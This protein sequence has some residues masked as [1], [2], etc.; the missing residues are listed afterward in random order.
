MVWEGGWFCSMFG[1]A[2]NVFTC[3]QGRAVYCF[4]R[5]FVMVMQINWCCFLCSNTELGVN[6]TQKVTE[7]QQLGLRM[8]Q[9][10]MS[11]G[12]KNRPC[13]ISA[14]WQPLHRITFLQSTQ[15]GTTPLRGPDTGLYRNSGSQA[16]CWS[17]TLPP[18]APSWFLYI[19]F[20]CNWTPLP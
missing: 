4:S 20:K 2:W 10:K 8:G 9:S 15:M 5:T 13:S 18:T 11:D 14:S 17:K 1:C 7:T 6:I 19:L 16:V 3:L 12:A